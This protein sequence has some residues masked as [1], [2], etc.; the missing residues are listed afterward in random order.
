MIDSLSRSPDTAPLR[1][2]SVPLASRFLLAPLAGY[3]TLAF[4]MAV[5]AL[6]GLGLATTDL[7]NA[8]ALLTRSRRTMELIKTCPED[9]PV[10]VQIYGTN[11]VEMR[12]AAQWLEGYGVSSIDINMGCPVHK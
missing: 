5:R 9:R 1:W 6:G 7:V 12:D 8:R 11:P 3:T 2:G 10:S 4:R